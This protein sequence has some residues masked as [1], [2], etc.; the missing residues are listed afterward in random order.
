MEQVPR[1]RQLSIDIGGMQ[2]R[3]H[4]GVRRAAAFLGFSEH[5]LAQ[6][7]PASLSLG[8]GRVQLLPTPLPAELREEIRPNYRDWIIGN[9]LRELDQFLSLAADEAWDIVEAVRVA[10][11][12]HPPA[13]EWR[14]IDRVTNVSEKHRTVLESI[15]GFEAPHVEDNACLASLS[16]VR[17]CLSHNLGI[18]DERRAANGVL[19][20]MWLAVRIQ[21]NAGGVVTVLDNDTLPLDAPEGGTLEVRVI[22]KEKVFPV[23]TH[24]TFTPDELMEICLFFNMVIDRFCLAIEAFAKAAGIAFPA[25]RAADADAA[26]QSRASAERV[27]SSD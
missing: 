13:H 15:Q 17:N 5:F 19:V 16:A 12:Q 1:Q 26:K 23:G 18:V 21:L 22:V 4:V 3:A 24:V 8:N 2:E 20:A 6:D 14:R 9:A 11:G 7:T 27:Q 10:V 25:P